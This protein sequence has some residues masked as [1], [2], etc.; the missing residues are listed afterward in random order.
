MR[1]SALNRT[2]HIPKALS[3]APSPNET[4][5]G[6]GCLTSSPALADRAGQAFSSFPLTSHLLQLSI[7]LH[8]QP[9]SPKPHSLRFPFPQLCLYIHPNL[10]IS[11]AR[12]THKP[13]DSRCL[14]PVNSSYLLRSADFIRNEYSAISS[15][16]FGG[17]SKGIQ[18]PNSCGALAGAFFLENSRL[19]SPLGVSKMFETRRPAFEKFSRLGNFLRRRLDSELDKER[20][21]HDK[22]FSPKVVGIWGPARP[23]TAT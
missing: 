10:G 18:L 2:V 11:W 14:T 16:V 22:R 3:G 4:N 13:G 19:S 1:A 23:F 8:T 6:C 17:I 20:E 21:I 9:R 15:P 5:F 12:S 7:A